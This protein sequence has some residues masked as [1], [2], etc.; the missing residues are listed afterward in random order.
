[1]IVGGAFG[2]GGDEFVEIFGAGVV[3]G[4]VA[5]LEH[6]DV[7]GGVEDLL[8]KFGGLEGGGVVRELLDEGAEAAESGDA[9]EIFV[10][11]GFDGGPERNAALIGEFVEALDGFIAD[12]ARGRVDDTE[13]RDI[14]VVIH[15]EARVSEGV[16]DFGTLIE[17]EPADDAIVRAELAERVFKGA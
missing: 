9:A 11:G 1:L 5:L 13:K 8:E 3:F 16:L 7:A 15:G 14:V 4:G 10:D 6:V 12:A 17:A 2:D